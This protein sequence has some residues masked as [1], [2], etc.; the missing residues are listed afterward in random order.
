MRSLRFLLVV[1]LSATQFSCASE[2]PGERI[3]TITVEVTGEEYNWYFR[4]P[5][6]DGELNT[7]DDKFSERNLYL[8][9]NTDVTLKL[10]SKDYVYNITLPDIDQKEIAVPD[11]DFQMTFR[12]S[13]KDKWQFKGDQFCGYSHETLIGEVFIRDQVSE[14]FYKW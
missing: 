1:L 3:D 6:P 14:D 4:Y 12:T 11:L 2:E 9:D 10:A 5:G 8:P 13:N 7:E